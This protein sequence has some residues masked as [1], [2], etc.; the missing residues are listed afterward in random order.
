MMEGLRHKVDMAEL[1]PPER[2]AL[3]QAQLA[4]AAKK[5]DNAPWE[6]LLRRRA[7][8]LADVRDLVARRPMLAELWPADR[9]QHEPTE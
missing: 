7:E 8:L 3:V 6:N 5:L 2:S 1:M 4:L 9:F